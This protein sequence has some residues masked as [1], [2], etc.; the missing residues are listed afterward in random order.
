MNDAT[1]LMYL[2]ER[3]DTQDGRIDVLNERLERERVENARLRTLV[4]RLEEL[5][6]TKNSQIERLNGITNVVLADQ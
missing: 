2:R 5:V 6:D 1:E 3:C 4:Q